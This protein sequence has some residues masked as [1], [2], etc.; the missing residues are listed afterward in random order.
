MAVV[1]RFLQKDIYALNQHLLYGTVPPIAKIHKSRNQGVEMERNHSSLSLE[2]TCK[3]FA[4]CS[5]HLMLCWPR[6]LVSKGRKACTG[7]QNGLTELEAKTSPWSFGLLKP[8]SK[9]AKNCW[10]LWCIPIIPALGE[11]RQENHWKFEAILVYIVPL[12]PGWTI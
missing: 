9:Q 1:C 12:K 8:L 2:I 10:A 5:H 3:M 11:V 4:F 6:S 7:K